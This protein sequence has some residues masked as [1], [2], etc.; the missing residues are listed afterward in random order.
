LDQNGLGF[1]VPLIVASRFAKRHYVSHVRHEYGSLLKFIEY[2]W[3]LPSL[4]TTDAR[5]DNLLDFFDFSA[6]NANRPFKLVASVHAG[7]NATF[8]ET[9]VKL[10][11]QPLDYTPEER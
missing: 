9:Q 3:K 2:N 6:T 7:V 10:D 8:F 1:R 4:R 11:T 5:A